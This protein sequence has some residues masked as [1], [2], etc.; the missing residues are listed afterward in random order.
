MSHKVTIALALF[1]GAV[2]GVLL[3]LGFACIGGQDYQQAKN[4]EAE[5]CVNVKNGV[6]PDFKNI[7]EKV[8]T[9]R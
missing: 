5:Y 3:G 9:E 8:C 7:F 1:K 4:D 6:W 2:L